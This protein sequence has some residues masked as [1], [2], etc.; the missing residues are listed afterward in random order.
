MFDHLQDSSELDK[1]TEQTETSV[2]SNVTFTVD[3]E[4]GNTLVFVC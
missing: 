1:Q 2:E 3:S 4:T